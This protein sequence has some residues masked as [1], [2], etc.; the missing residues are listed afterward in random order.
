MKSI[1]EILL[2]DDNETNIYSLT[3]ILDRLPVKLLSALSGKE[4]LIL[5]GKHNF[6]LALVDIQMPDMDGFE[7]LK[8]LRSTPNHDQ[9]PVILISAIYTEDQYRIKGMATG[10]VDFIPKPVSPEIIRAKVKVFL[11]LEQQ[12]RQLNQLVAEL[13]K[14]NKQLAAEIKN[15]KKIESELRKARA[16]AEKNSEIKNQLL[17]NMS[18]EIRTPVNSILGFAD[19]ITNPDIEDVDKERYVHYVSHS[20]QNLLF[21]IDEILDHS[22][23]EAGELKIVTGP[24]CI[25]DLLAELYEAFEKIKDQ[26]DKNNINLILELAKTDKKL[27]IQ[28]DC[29]R[30][31]QIISNLLNNAL[32][33]SKEGEIRFGMEPKGNHIEFW[34]HDTGVG[35][36]KEDLDNIFDR[37]KRIENISDLKASGTGL[38]L[39]LCKNLVT[40]LGGTIRVTSKPN[41][42]SEFRFSLPM[43][44]STTEEAVH[45]DDEITQDTIDWSAHT[46]LIAEDEEMNFMFLQEALKVTGI[47]IVWAKNGSEAVEM[48][49]NTPEIDVVLMDIKMPD[50]DGYQATAK[51]KSFNPSIPVI[52]QTAMALTDNQG[53]TDA[54]NADFDDFITKPISRTT[55]IKILSH[56]LKNK[57]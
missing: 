16:K 39:S 4:A 41:V 35:I 31:R 9:L 18:H 36:A 34:V 25:H 52:I 15:R 48:V 37:F 23:L 30:L 22:R 19:L 27:T 10:A 53:K 21:L 45:E 5:A 7:T 40:L 47:H 57:D 56:F 11:E 46:L 50:M 1:P 44:M 38:G 24:C 26:S 6:T 2:V 55:L 54:Q 17:V 29:Q 20:S 12:K 8:R 49:K 28:T 32:K 3:K 14:K 42:G 33:Y 43:K 13:K 51:V